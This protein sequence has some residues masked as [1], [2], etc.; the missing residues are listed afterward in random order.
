[1]Q[2][3]VL[4]WRRHNN[5]FSTLPTANELNTNRN[6]I[7][8]KTKTKRTKQKQTNNK[9]KQTR[10]KKEMY[11]VCGTQRTVTC[12]FLV[13]KTHKGIMY[14]TSLYN[15]QWYLDRQIQEFHQRFEEQSVSQQLKCT[16]GEECTHTCTC[17][18]QFSYMHNHVHVHEYIQ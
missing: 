8:H 1:M 13:E 15:S 16:V 17:I 11:A 4:P 7:K 14:C 12:L 3:R 2:Q 5:A 6:L 18:L 10:K 9:T